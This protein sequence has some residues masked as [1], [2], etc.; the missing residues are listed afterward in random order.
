VKENNMLRVI[1]EVTADD[2]AEMGVTQEQLEETVRDKMGSLDVEGDA[3]YFNDLGV[4][5]VVA[6]H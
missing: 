5:V 1:V 3:L 2:L 4:S 6:E